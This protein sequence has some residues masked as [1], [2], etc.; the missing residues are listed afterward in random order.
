MVKM[1]AMPVKDAMEYG[2]NA[3]AMFAL[4]AELSDICPDLHPI[5]S[6]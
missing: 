1:I 3:T 5:G 4:L 2:E 6:L